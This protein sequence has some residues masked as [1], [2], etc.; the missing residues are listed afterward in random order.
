M[1]GLVIV[2][3]VLAGLAL[4]GM[5]RAALETGP[6]IARSETD[7]RRL[8]GA[9]PT[10]DPAWRCVGH[11]APQGGRTPSGHGV[12]GSEHAEGTRVGFTYREITWTWVKGGKSASDSWNVKP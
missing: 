11:P 9:R 4:P 5:A 2:L 3:G 8:C 7:A 6:Q 1:R 12:V 10:S